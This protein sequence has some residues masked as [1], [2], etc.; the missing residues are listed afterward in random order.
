MANPA[1]GN[2]EATFW[3][4]VYRAMLAM[5]EQALIR[6]RKILASHLDNGRHDNDHLDDVDLVLKEV[7]RVRGRLAY[8][9]G[10]VDGNSA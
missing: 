1:I 10:L 4:G 3:V 6:M 5:D 2:R 8:W 9:S 7:A